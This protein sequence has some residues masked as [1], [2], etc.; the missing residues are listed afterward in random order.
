VKY[1]QQPDQT[2][3]DDWRIRQTGIYHQYRSDTKQSIVILFSPHP[4][5]LAEQVFLQQIDTVKTWQDCE[6]FHSRLD[7]KLLDLHMSAWRQYAQQ[8]ETALQKLVS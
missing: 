8:N 5:S 1:A 7:L 6:Q 4:A 2:T 3:P